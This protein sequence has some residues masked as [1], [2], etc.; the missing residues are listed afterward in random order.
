MEPPPGE[1][2]QGVVF[3]TCSFQAI[4]YNT[5]R[6]SSPYKVRYRISMEIPLFVQIYLI[7]LFTLFI[8]FK[9]YLFF[10]GSLSSHAD[11]RKVSRRQRRSRGNPS[12]PVSLIPAQSPEYHYD[13]GLRLIKIGELSRAEFY[14]KYAVATKPKWAE[15]RYHLALTLVRLR[16]LEEARDH[17][18][19]L[20][21]IDLELARDLER[22]MYAL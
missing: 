18:R 6:S 8:L 21:E 4:V 15:P 11:G 10:R 7:F 19:E 5:N 22:E 16:R 13:Q 12:E 20:K 9:I 17:L 1:V 14:L 2:D 3:C